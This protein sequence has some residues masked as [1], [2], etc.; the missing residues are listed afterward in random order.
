MNFQPLH[1]QDLCPGLRHDAA[2]S[3]PAKI[4]WCEIPDLVRVLWS[5]TNPSLPTGPY[6]GP[7]RART[8]CLIT[9]AVA[10]TTIVGGCGDDDTIET[11]DDSAVASTPE[12][13][14]TGDLTVFAASSLTDAFT[15]IGDAFESAHPGIDV[16]LNFAS[17][18]DLAGQILEGAPADVFASADTV[19]MTKL[20]DESATAGAPATFATNSLA[21]MVEPGNPHDIVD[22]ADLTDDLIV[23]SCDPDVPI[24]RYTQ[25]VLADADVQVAMDSFEENVR[26]VAAKVEAGEADAGI[27]YATD[28]SAAG[29]SATGVTIPDDVNV[30]ADYP[31]AVTAD[32]PHPEAADA[33]EAFVI[34][35]EGQQIL[36][37]YGFGPP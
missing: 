19:N 21:I 33:F 25:Q 30:V 36:A 29:D 17:S 1:G 35:P 28:I 23:I 24:G 10:L 11:S 16:T 9:V 5:Y 18:S 2:I 15:D 12:A 14:I 22:L 34:G 4:G 8:F 6:S 7:V 27:V 31:V 20:T 26:A 13:G 3:G 32:A 37:G